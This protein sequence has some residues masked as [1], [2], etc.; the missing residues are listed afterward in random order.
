MQGRGERTM[1]TDQTGLCGRVTGVAAIDHNTARERSGP[2]QNLSSPGPAMRHIRH[3]CDAC[4]ADAR[5]SIRRARGQTSR[6]LFFG[7]V[8]ILVRGEDD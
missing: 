7:C 8:R 4:D 2:H 1:R 5:G 6:M 3:A